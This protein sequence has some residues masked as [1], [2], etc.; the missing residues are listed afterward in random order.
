MDKKM[1]ATIMGS[2]GTTTI[3]GVWPFWV[4]N[5][6]FSDCHPT[7]E[8]M[9]RVHIKN[10]EICFCILFNYYCWRLVYVVLDNM[11]GGVACS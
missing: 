9:Q 3:R 6:T 11:L 8:R 10:L 1:E 5:R 2:I 7:W 4:F